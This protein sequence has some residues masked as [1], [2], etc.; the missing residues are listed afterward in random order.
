M[1]QSSPTGPRIWAAVLGLVLIPAAGMA[2][3]LASMPIARRVDLDAL[4]SGHPVGWV[5]LDF[6]DFAML[7]LFGP[8]TVVLLSAT[9][10]SLVRAF[11]GRG[12]VLIHYGAT[13]VLLVAILV[14]TSGI[15]MVGL[16]HGNVVEMLMGLSCARWFF[17]IMQK[18]RRMRAKIVGEDPVE[19]PHDRSEEDE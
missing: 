2:G 5:P 16:T 13:M 19:N 6:A 4:K 7:G 17:W 11:T 8:M 9:Y 1:D 14:M 12:H 15:V 3:L 18:F 10:N